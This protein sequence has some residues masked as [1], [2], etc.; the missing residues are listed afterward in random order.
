MRAHEAA[1]YLN[2]DTM[3]LRLGFS[4]QRPPPVPAARR[5]ARRLD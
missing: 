5:R 2:F 3:R 4:A 1:G